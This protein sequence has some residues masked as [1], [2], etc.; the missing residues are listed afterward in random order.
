M[1]FIDNK[2]T[3]VY[4]QI[5]ERAKARIIKGYTENHHIIP[6]SLGGNNSKENLVQL[7]AREHF[8]CHWLLAKMVSSKKQK[9]Q[10][11]NAISSMLDRENPYQSRYVGFSR[12]FEFLREEISRQ[13]SIKFSGVNNPMF[14][15]THSP[16]AI[17]KIRKRHI[18][19]K[20]TEE[21]KLKCKLAYKHTGPNYKLR[22]KNN[23]NF[24]P[25]VQEKMRKTFEENWGEGITKP[26]KIPFTCEHCGKS[27][28]GIGN[29]KR[30]HGDNCKSI[31][32]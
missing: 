21:T 9:Y 22:G 14:G 19:R 28:H 15:K 4:Y 17:E 26:G 20:I 3:R 25:G 2:Y 13:R 7:T 27:G 10:M 6:K 18:G 31:N 5:V 11:W 29:Y 24:K 8:I 12:K 30:W 23:A 16:E 32:S 1:I